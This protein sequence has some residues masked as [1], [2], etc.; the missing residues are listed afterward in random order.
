MDADIEET[1]AFLQLLPILD[2]ELVCRVGHR[3]V[4]EP[5]RPHYTVG[6]DVHLGGGSDVVPLP[7]VGM[8]GVDLELHEVEIA[9]PSI[10]LAVA[11]H[12]R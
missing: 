1:G 4:I 8:E 11:Q 5:P 2:D 6:V 7:R 10:K 9:Y 3:L 12:P